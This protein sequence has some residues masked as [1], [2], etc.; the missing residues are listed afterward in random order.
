MS[1]VINFKDMEFP[2]E[3][4]SI[5]LK[6]EIKSVIL[7]NLLRNYSIT[8]NN[9]IKD[10]LKK[11]EYEKIATEINYP[12][13]IIENFVNNFLVD[14]KNFNSF[15]E[16]YR[17]KWQYTI[18]RLNI[19]VRIVLYKIFRICPVFNYRRA[20]HNLGILHTLLEKRSFWPRIG[21][22]LAVVIYITDK[23]DKSIKNRNRILQK[24]IR[25]ICN[26]SA[27][28]FHRTRNLL[29]I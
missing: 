28:A 20:R 21:T 19:R 5:F 16:N 17:I 26:C 25:A 27:Y 11:I 1:K 14:V 13:K 15:Y 8:S 9:E 24:N 7:N 22:Q 10:S 3:N 23:N 2:A 4:I 12:L 29:R 18:N 6:K